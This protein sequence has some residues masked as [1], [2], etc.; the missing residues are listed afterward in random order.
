M[1]RILLF[2]TLAQKAGKREI[3]IEAVPDGKAVSLI[4]E[5]ITRAYLGGEAGIYM[6]AV[7]GE[8]VK[9]DAVVKDGDEVA[10][11]PPF[12]GG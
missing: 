12:S 1:I 4:A 6:L 3:E 9:P 10:I 2:G 8:Q 11:M 7:N 5:E